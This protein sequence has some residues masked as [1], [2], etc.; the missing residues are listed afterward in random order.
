MEAYSKTSYVTNIFD[1]IIETLNK[2]IRITTSNEDSK[3]YFYFS[4]YKDLKQYFK[5]VSFA[6]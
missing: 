6:Q 1:R 3:I 5:V 4:Y 2:P